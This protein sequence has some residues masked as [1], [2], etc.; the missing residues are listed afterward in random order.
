MFGDRDKVGEVAGAGGGRALGRR[1]HQIDREMR[2]L[3]A[4]AVATIAE[5]VRTRAHGEDGHSAIGGW[6][7]AQTNW[8]PAETKARVRVARLAQRESSLVDAMASGELGVAQSR[9][10]G[11]AAANPRCGYQLGAV[12]PDVLEHAGKL[13]FEDFRLVVRRWEMLADTDGTHRDRETSHAGR[14]A[15]LTDGDACCAKHNRF[16]TRARITVTRDE[17]GYLHHWRPDG[18][19]IGRP[20]SDP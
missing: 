4:E 20:G 2:R 9:E 15:S 7:R 1:L 5:A 17:H 13:S 18:T 10:L 19:E 16:T 14:S 8:S 12:L 6:C 3:E 11:R